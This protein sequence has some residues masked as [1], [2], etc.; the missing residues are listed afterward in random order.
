[1]NFRILLTTL[2]L[3][4]IQ[5]MQG[6]STIADMEISSID[7]KLSIATFGAG[8]FWCIEAVFQELKGVEKVISGYSGGTIKNPAYREITSGLS[9]H[10]EV[11]QIYFDASIISF[12]ELLEVF[13]KTHD[14]TTLNRQ[15]ADRGTQY[16]S[17]IFYHN[18][19]QKIAAEFYLR[20]LDGSEAFSNPIVTEI[21]SF[22]VFYQADNSHQDFYKENADA[23]YCNYVIVPKLEKFR[24]AFA[25]KLK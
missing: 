24:A 18:Q 25:D 3:S 5:P 2:F 21:S 1:M 4:T 7:N 14:P 15:G 20:K 6:F 16:R 11:A 19:E 22:D 9:G 8:C 17:V 12:E 10:A 13:W 23:P